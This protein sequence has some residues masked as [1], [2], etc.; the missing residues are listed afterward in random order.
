MRFFIEIASRP[1]FNK[2]VKELVY[3]RRFFS[4]ILAINV[5][6]PSHFDDHFLDFCRHLVGKSRSTGTQWSMDWLSDVQVK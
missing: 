2:H 6:Y 3:V 5:P 4:E 1:L